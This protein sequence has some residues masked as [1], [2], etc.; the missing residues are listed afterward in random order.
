M[1]KLSV[2]TDEVSQDFS[3]VLRFLERHEL[4]GVEIRSLWNMPPQRL[5]SRAGEIR[6]ELGKRGLEVSAIASPFYKADINNEKEVKEHL[7]ILKSCIELA[8]T[9]D[10]DIIRVFTFWRKGK[11][12]DYVDRIVEL[13]E[14]PVDIAEDEGVTLA[15]EN[16]PSTFATNAKLV[17]DFIRRIGSRHV[18]AVFDPGN[19]L[20]DPLGEKPYPDGYEAL[21][22]YI[23]HVHV[24]DG[25]RAGRE[26][27]EWLP[28]GEGEVDY[29]GLIKALVME[30]YK[31]YLSL[32]THWRPKRRLERRLEQMPGGEAF[33]S[34]GEEASDVSIRGLK[35]IIADVLGLD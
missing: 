24:K 32:E 7:G 25:R 15:V 21:K 35:K 17:A 34:L 6:S 14:E 12:E 2:I 1:F 20:A 28:V 16:E 23:V 10:T 18:R 27:A 4:D 26:E 9:L 31:G 13:Y 11:W 5:L 29:R 3:V 22:P 19:D 33:S 8:K 30:G